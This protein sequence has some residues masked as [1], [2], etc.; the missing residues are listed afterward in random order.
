MADIGLPTI[1][2][3]LI[4]LL[5]VLR[6]LEMRS[7]RRRE[8]EAG[9]ASSFGTRTVQQDYFS[10]QKNHGAL[11]MLLADGLGENGEIAAKLAV[12]TFRDLFTDR[13]AVDKPQ[14]FFQRASNAAHKR[15]VN[16]LE[17]RQGESS[18]AAVVIN[19]SRMTYM[20]V[21]NCRVTIFRDGEL[22]NVSEGQTIDILARHRYAE[23]RITRQET[24]AL[25]KHR[26]YNLLGQD[27][28]HEIEI[29]DK[30]LELRKNDLVAVMSEGVFNTLRR[31][32][33]ENVLS[34]KKSARELAD[35]L[36]ERVNESP[37][38][39]KDNAS[40]IIYRQNEV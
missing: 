33:I 15:I 8:F 18:L 32:D 3:S 16:T 22:I 21:G 7:R 35:E 40:I 14:Y 2:F 29:F 17:E 4:V 1:L 23:G 5:Y 25:E 39:D 13:D 24:L 19:D 36:I 11:L 6:W 20:V 27:V 9:A 31:V 28:F 34:Q 12:D 38:V 37:S 30:P 10:V 26:Q